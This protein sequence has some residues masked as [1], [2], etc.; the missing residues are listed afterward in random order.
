MDDHHC[1]YGYFTT[2]TRTWFFKRVSDRNFQVS[3]IIHADTKATGSSV[4][5]RECFLYFGYLAKVKDGEEDSAIY[6]K[7]IGKKLVSP[8]EPKLI[9][10]AILTVEPDQ[11]EVE[12]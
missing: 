8:R 12:S 6:K 11:G 4:S 9:R 1:R 5:L 10:K 7:R 3:S 2:Y